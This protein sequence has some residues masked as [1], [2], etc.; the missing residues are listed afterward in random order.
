M[1]RTR[2]S[3]AVFLLT[4][5]V[6]VAAVLSIPELSASDDGEKVISCTLEDMGL[7]P[8]PNS[9]GR[10]VVR[11]TD[12]LTLEYDSSSDVSGQ[13]EA[14]FTITNRGKETVYFPAEGDHGLLDVWVWERIGESDRPS[15]FATYVPSWKLEQGEK[16]EFRINVAKGAFPISMNFNYWLG[17]GRIPKEA[18]IDVYVQHVI[19]A[20]LPVTGQ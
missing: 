12:P 8:R 19:P 11:I 15:S 4:F 18:R 7:T 20:V 1:C 6:G 5:I 3:I 14:T 9:S 10:R 13:M 2:S 17:D 16:A